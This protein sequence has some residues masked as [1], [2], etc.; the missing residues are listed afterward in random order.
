MT[1]NQGRCEQF[2]L[3]SRLTFLVCLY[4]NFNLAFDLL[5]IF[6]ATPSPVRDWSSSTPRYLTC[7]WQAR[8]LPA[9]CTWMELFCWSFLFEAKSIDSVFPRWRDKLLSI[10]HSLIDSSS[11]ES[12]FWISSVFVPDTMRA[13]SSAYKSSLHPTAD[14]TS[15]TYIRNSN[16]PRIDPRISPQVIVAGLEMVPPIST[17]CWRSCR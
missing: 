12:L 11:E 16:R 7:V 10:S 14:G 2:F 8:V 9:H 17:D 4:R 13:G 6:S 15:F 1:L 5:I 3:V